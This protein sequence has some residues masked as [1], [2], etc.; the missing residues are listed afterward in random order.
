MQDPCKGQTI[1]SV[2]LR[3]SLSAGIISNEDKESLI[4]WV[5]YIKAVQVIDTSPAP[6]INWPVKPE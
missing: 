2:L 3:H 4:A 1:R 5:Q 6:N